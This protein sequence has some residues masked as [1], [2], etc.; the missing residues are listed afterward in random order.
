[1]LVLFSKCD[2]P[3]DV[4]HRSDLPPEFEFGLLD[5]QI[6]RTSKGLWTLNAQK[7]QLDLFDCWNNWCY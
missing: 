4:C 1:M 6:L 5:T 3:S 7:T 2:R